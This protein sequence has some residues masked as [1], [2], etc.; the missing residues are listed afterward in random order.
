MAVIITSDGLVAGSIYTFM[1][2]S[3]NAIDSSDFSDTVEAGISDFPDQPTTLS[4]SSID[5]VSITLSWSISLDKQLPVIGYQLQMDDGYGGDFQTIY[6]GYNFP[7]VRQYTATGLTRG[8]EYRFQ[9][10]ALNF[11]GPGVASSTL[12]VYFCSPPSGLLPPTLLSSTQTS[13]TLQWSPPTDDGGCPVLEYTLTRDDGSGP[14]APIDVIVDPTDFQG[15]PSL[16]EHT[17][18]FSPADTSK[19]FKFQIAATAVSVV[20]SESVTFVVTAKPDAPTSA[21]TESIAQTTGSQIAVVYSALPTTSN[22]GSDITSYELQIYSITNSSWISLVGGTSAPSL[23]NTYTINSGITQGV[24]YSFKYRAFNVNGAGDF[25]SIGY[26]VAAQRP[27]QPSAPEYVISDDTSVTLGFRPPSSNG[28]S[29]ITK[30]VLEYSDFA[31]LNWQIDTTYTDNSMSHILAVSSGLVTSYQK[32]RFRIYWENTFGTS[33]YSD[34]FALAIASLPSKWA[35]SAK[36]QSNRT[37]TS[38]SIQWVAPSETEPIIGYLVYITDISGGGSYILAYDG[39]SNPIRLTYTAMLLTPEK[40]YGFKV[41]AINFKG[42]GP[43]G[44]EAIFESWEAPKS[45]QAPTIGQVTETQISIT[46]SVPVSN[47]GCSTT[48]FKLWMDDGTGRSLFETAASDIEGKPYLRSYTIVFTDPT[49]TG[50]SFRIR[51]EAFNS[52]GSVLS[53]IVSVVLA[54]VPATPTT[55]PT[56]D[57]TNT[58]AY[59]IGVN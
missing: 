3:V 41:L 54:Q 38:I 13:L 29:I 12:D 55:G 33:D 1:Q 47:G 4:V 10:M 28:G 49:A 11:N 48:G 34:K 26:L 20:T 6:N 39:S 53:P 59:Q 23:T 7:N 46:W 50:K 8:L 21:L 45:L 42:N 44:S 43:L 25:S 17:V 2:R 56:L 51:L 18:T 15:E 24:T 57:L 9:L 30:Y 37:M 27:S 40:S 31:T 5:S 14:S 19:S 58:N 32:Y 16:R 52:V 22:G 36:S 35:A